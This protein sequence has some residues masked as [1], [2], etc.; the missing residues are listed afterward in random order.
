MTG[1]AAFL[2]SIGTVITQFFTWV[3]D[4]GSV[5]LDNPFLTLFVAVFFVFVVVRLLKK[6]IIRG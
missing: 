1:L 4:A 5:I 2:T 3:G 6:F